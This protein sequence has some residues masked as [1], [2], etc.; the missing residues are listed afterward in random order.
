MK[1]TTKLLKE[2]IRKELKEAMDPFEKKGSYYSRGLVPDQDQLAREKEFSDKV[3]SDM[4]NEKKSKYRAI[5][6]IVD[7]EYDYLGDPAELSREEVIGYLKGSIYQLDSSFPNDNQIYNL[8]LNAVDE[9]DAM[10]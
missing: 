9:V 3:L 2:M 6:S 8:Y 4:D 1:L 7:E 10:E 5:V